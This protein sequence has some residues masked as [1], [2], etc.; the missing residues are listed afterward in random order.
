MTEVD[1]R[2]ACAKP[3]RDVAHRKRQ[4]L[5]PAQRRLVFAKTAGTCHVCGMPLGSQWHADH[6]VQ[7]ARGGLHSLDNF[8]PICVVCNGLRWSYPPSMF[9]V[10]IML[11]ICAKQEVRH[12]TEIGDA[13][14]ALLAKRHNR[15][16]RRRTSPRS[17]RAV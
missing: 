14:V 13:L 1:I 9:R 3:P 10:I 7:H 8:L 11:G 17:T 4:R 16:A 5:T 15:N 12:Q 2:S 6:V